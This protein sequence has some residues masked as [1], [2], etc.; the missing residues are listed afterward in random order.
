MNLIEQLSKELSTLHLNDFEKARYIY[1]RCCEIFSFDSRYTYASFF[2]DDKIRNKILNNR[3]NPE[4]IKDT[5]CV[6]TSFSPLVKYL[7]DLL[8]SL[9]SNVVYINKHCF[10]ILDYKGKEWI[11]DATLGDI[12]RVK[13]DL[14]TQGFTLDRLKVEREPLVKDIDMSLGFGN[15][16]NDDYTKLITGNTL[17]ENVES[18]GKILSNSKAKYHFSD[19]EFL[20]DEVL[21]CSGYDGDVN[22]YIGDKYDFH[23][24]IHI[25]RNDEYSFFDI[26]K[27]DTEY[28][29]KRIKRIDYDVYKKYL[30]HK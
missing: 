16:T 9:N 24:L 18:I 27:E 17:T 2:D 4:D 21:G 20:L 28:T 8:T 15:K 19:V 10:L 30:R 14:P 22:P 7:I 23:R 26:S 6:C 25:N 5:R 3:F 29:L 13:L 12:V 11:L 1:L